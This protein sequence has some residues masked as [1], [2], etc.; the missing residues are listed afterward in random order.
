MY[1]TRTGREVKAAVV[2]PAYK[3]SRHIVQVI[4]KIPKEIDELVVVVDA[5]PEGTSELLREYSFERRVHLIEHSENTGVGGAMKSGYRKAVDLGAE[6]VIK[7]DGD[8]QMDT[9]LIA[10]LIEPILSGDAHY[11]KGNRF[12][13]FQ[14]FKNMPKVR[15]IGNLALSFFSK[16]S[17]G[18]YHILD[19]N[20]G[21][22][23]ISSEMID[24]IDFT[25]VDNR[26]FFETDM[27]FNLNLLKANVHDV[28]MPSIYQDEIS[29]LK[30][31][32]SLMYFFIRHVRNTQ[33]RII[34]NYFLR[35]FSLA[36]IQLLLGL[37]LAS[38]GTSLGLITWFHSQNAG[39]PSQPGTIVLV[40]ILCL[41]GLQLLLSFIHYDMSLNRR[42][43]S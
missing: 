13:S 29:N 11:T 38:W 21:F 6:I 30:V 36:S 20:N 23:A 15:L 32:H 37:I 17:T 35:D 33:R 14:F 34:I 27:L 16:L 3:V 10:K 31:S 5:C 7:V 12:H 9:Q 40:A 28:P 22:T 42:N 19:P 41:S 8:G 43:Q 26:F 18:Y 25:E 24:L 4:E 39:I 1:L 2:I